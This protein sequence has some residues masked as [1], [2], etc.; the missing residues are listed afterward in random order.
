[1]PSLDT[2]AYTIKQW[3]HEADVP[4]TTNVLASL[5]DGRPADG[6][7]TYYGNIDT[8]GDNDYFALTVDGW[9]ILHIQ[10]AGGAASNAAFATV[11][12]RRRK[13]CQLYT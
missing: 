8:G 2:G 10:F 4:G 12:K 1:M 5:R 6:L 11:G 9:T 7:G 13:P 3:S